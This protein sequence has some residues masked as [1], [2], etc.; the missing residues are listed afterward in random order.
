MRSV[1]QQHLDVA[2]YVQVRLVLAQQFGLVG[3]LVGLQVLSV[4]SDVGPRPHVSEASDVDLQDAVEGVPPPGRGT[5]N[6][7][8]GSNTDVLS[9]EPA[10]LHVKAY[11]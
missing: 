3:S 7:S 9:V 2:L 8:T 6:K 5:E 10:V 4:L 1:S 11:T